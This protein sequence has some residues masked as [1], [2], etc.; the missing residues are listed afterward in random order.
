MNP[1]EERFDDP[2]EIAAAELMDAQIA[3][4]LGGRAEPTTDPTVLWLASSLRPPASQ[5]LHDR[6]AQQVRT[7]HARTWRFVQLAAVALGLLLAIQGINGYVLGDWISRN[8][9]EPFAEHASIDAAFAYIAAGAAVVAGAIKRRWLPVSVLAGVPLGLLLTAHGVH[10]FSEFAYG[11]ALHFA[12]G[13]CAIALLV[14]WLAMRRRQH[15]RRR[16]GD[17]SDPQDE[18]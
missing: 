14:G 8:L 7:H 9:G 13:A 10:E 17:D 2:A 18:V 11:A 5:T 12:E 4:T 1:D 15:R 6:V 3:A 16:Y